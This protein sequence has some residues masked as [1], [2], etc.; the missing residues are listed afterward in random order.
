M[1]ERRDTE[2]WR[3]GDTAAMGRS[4]ESM[5]RGLPSWV[6]GSQGRIQNLVS[7]NSGLSVGG[8]LTE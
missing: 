7:D 8:G 6:Q 3:K 1:E 2:E 4:Q 5:R